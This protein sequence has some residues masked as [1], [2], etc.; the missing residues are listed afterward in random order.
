MRC[1]R[2][3]HAESKVIDSRPSAENDSIRRR[4]ECESCNFR[5]TTYERIESEMPQV[6]KRDG[7]RVP[8]DRESIVAGVRK[9][10]EKRPISTD[11]IHALIDEVERIILERGESEVPSTFIGEKVM[12]GLHGLDDV[13]Y[14][15]FASVYRSFRD[16]EDFLQ[17]LKQFLDK[18]R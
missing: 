10:C 6:V 2:C 5:F 9:A 18:P 13:A 8:Y 11:Q 1:P 4:R 15:R 7:R 17:E 3:Q 14:V 12:E 16:A